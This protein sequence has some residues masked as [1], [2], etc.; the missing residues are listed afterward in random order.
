MS[1]KIWAY[2]C[3]LRMYNIKCKEENEMKNVSIYGIFQNTC[4]IRRYLSK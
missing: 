2:S 4:R 3:I 1:D